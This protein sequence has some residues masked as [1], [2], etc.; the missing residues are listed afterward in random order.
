MGHFTESVEVM[1]VCDLLLNGYTT[2]EIE[3]KLK[4]PKQR[5]DEIYRILQDATAYE[6]G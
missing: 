1:Q 5:V 4:I 2:T 6:E 3:T